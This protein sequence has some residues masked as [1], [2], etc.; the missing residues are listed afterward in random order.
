MKRVAI[1]R[2][3][4]AAISRENNLDH[5]VSIIADKL[6]EA[7]GVDGVLIYLKNDAK[8]EMELRQHRGISE[9]TSYQFSRFANRRPPKRV[10]YEPGAVQ[11]QFRQS[12]Y[13]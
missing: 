6:T 7:T 8:N 11:R 9:E 12:N 3:I 1:L 2:T 5:I 4:T 13:L 10:F